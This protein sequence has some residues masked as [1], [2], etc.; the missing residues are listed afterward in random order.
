MKFKAL[1]VLTIT[2]FIVFIIYL[3]NI[4]NKIYYLTLGDYLVANHSEDSYT[5]LIKKDL[6]KKRKLETYVT[7]FNRDSARITDLLNDIES[8][9][10]IM[11]KDKEKTLKN[12]L[13]KA[14]LTIVS[15]GS[16]DLFY[17]LETH[18]KL[19]ESLYDKVDQILED[20]RKLYTLLRK[21]C[22]ED[23]FVTG[24]YNP[25]DVEYDELVEYANTKLE[26]ILKEEDITYINIQKCINRH[27]DSQ[28][29]MLTEEEN[30]CI[31]NKL[32]TRMK[33]Q[34]FED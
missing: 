25:Y 19:T 24:F 6:Q 22:K 29:L 20:S 1:L 30:Q 10:K 8:N 16:N 7:G 21:Y 31:A 4:D 12:A 11:I 33:I 26:K 13:I 27:N 15:V 5:N 34:L 17:E 23:I 9:K 28:K 18:P 32:A 14:D 3:S 2:I